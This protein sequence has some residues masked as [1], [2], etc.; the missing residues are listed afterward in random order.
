VHAGAAGLHLGPEF[1]LDG[2]DEVAAI[3]L[4]LERQ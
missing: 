3:A 4:D 1:V 2:R